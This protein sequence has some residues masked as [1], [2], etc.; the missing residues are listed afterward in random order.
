MFRIYHIAL[1][2]TCFLF[3]AGCAQKTHTVKQEKKKKSKKDI[4]FDDTRQKTEYIFIEGVRY[5]I[6][7]QNSNAQGAFEKVL[8]LD[9]GNHAAHYKIAEICFEKK[10]LDKALYHATQAIRG[11]DTNEFYYVL[12]ARVQEQQS[13]TQG[14]LKTYQ[15]LVRKVPS[16]FPYYME[17]ADLYATENNYQKVIEAYDKLEEHTGAD[18]EISIQKQRYYLLL[19]E[20]D[21]AVMEGEKLAEA[22]PDIPAYR[23]H[24]AEL[25]YSNEKYD[26][27]EKLLLDILADSPNQPHA[28]TTLTRLYREQGRQ[29]E[30]NQLLHRAFENPDIPVE[31][32]MD[33]FK[34]FLRPSAD[35]ATLKQ[36]L[37]LAHIIRQQHPDEARAHAVMGDVYL[38]M[39]KHREAREEYLAAIRLE[40][41][42][43]ELW[44]QVIVIDSELNDTDNM[45]THAVQATELFPN[46]SLFWYYAGT[47]YT[48]NKEYE[49]SVDALEQAKLL[50]V[51]NPAMQKAI[52]GMLADNYHYLERYDDSDSAY[53]S[54][55]SEDANNAH[56]LNNYSYFL[57]LREEKLDKA[58]EMATRL[59]TMYPDNPTYLDTYAWVLYVMGNYEQAKKY[60]AKALEKT[61]DG[62]VLEHYGDVLYQL[63]DTEQAVEYWKKARAQGGASD[64][65]DKKIT[66]RKLYE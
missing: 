59:V 38:R 45:I 62:T 32:K 23:I 54:V 56:A 41:D 44:R 46:Q 26:A 22:Y 21:K 4:A 43:Y 49:K 50:A 6:L 48:M 15:T 28:L 7:G 34:G 3:L 1:F 60:L 63:G 29:K 10:E 31:E 30:Y 2:F 40:E 11:D 47:G 9:P 53:E 25:L 61:D 58:K 35:S 37:D 65:I 27:A 14:A 64:L 24:L 20:L 66:D 19:G 52:N 18:P 12:K 13:D 16:A 51:N 17:I 5:Y 42:N 8:E 33:L 36:A 39:E 57:S 55:L